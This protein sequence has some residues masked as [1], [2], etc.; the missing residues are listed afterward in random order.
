MYQKID[1]EGALIP[2]SFE[3]ELETEVRGSCSAIYMGQMYIFGGAAETKQ[4]SVSRVY[5]KYLEAYKFLT[6]SDSS[7]FHDPVWPLKTIQNS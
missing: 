2:M 7:S 5:F 4:I 1:I 3:Y 6:S